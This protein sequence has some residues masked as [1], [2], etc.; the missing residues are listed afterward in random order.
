MS[1]HA[2]KRRA[3]RRGAAAVEFA[4]CLPV[5]T[6]LVFGSIQAC[7]LI[8]LRHGLMSA[9]YEGSI[10]ASRKNATNRL[11]VARIDEM[12]RVHDIDGAGATVGPGGMDLSAADPGDRVVITVQAPVATNLPLTRFFPA[13]ATLSVQLTC[14]R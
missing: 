2:K 12:L 1:L 7:E 3:P 4:V 11:V 5:L 8:Y 6:L 9:A 10:E 13:P 14:T